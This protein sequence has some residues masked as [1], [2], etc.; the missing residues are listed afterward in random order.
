M[1]NDIKCPYCNYENE[2]C[3]FPDLFYPDSN[4]SKELNKQAKLLEELQDHGYNIVTC[5]NCGQ[6]FITKK[7]A[8]NGVQILW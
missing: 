3:N 1:D 8:N 2:D 7:E 6:V 4:F 5:G